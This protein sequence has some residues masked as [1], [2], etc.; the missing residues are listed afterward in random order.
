MTAME[1][2]FPDCGSGGSEKAF[3]VWPARQTEMGG[4]RFADIGKSLAPPDRTGV[5]PRPESE[6][7]HVFAGVIRSLPGRVA[8]MVRG[9]DDEIAGLQP[10]L[11]L[12]QAPVERLERRRI[13]NDIAA[14]TVERVEIDEVGEDQVAVA[15]PGRGLRATGRTARRWSAP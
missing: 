5:D 13:A 11:Q 4:D 8:A 1:R 15:G 9:D 14:V 7:R 3:A 12:R 10:L 2:R 6:D